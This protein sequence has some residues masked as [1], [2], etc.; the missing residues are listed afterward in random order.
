MKESGGPI[1]TEFDP[2]YRIEII[3][4]GNKKKQE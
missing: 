3:V 2:G 1:L 4:E